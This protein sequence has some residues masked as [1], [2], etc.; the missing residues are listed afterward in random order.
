MY[1]VTLRIQT[2][3]KLIIYNYYCICQFFFQ[4]TVYLSDIE[5]YAYHTYND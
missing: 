3:I 4:D 1:F 5:K 2:V